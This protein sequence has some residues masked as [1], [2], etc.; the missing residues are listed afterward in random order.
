MR[1]VRIENRSRGTVLAESAMLADHFWT[2]MRGLLGRPC[3]GPGEGIVLV[4]C[5]QVHM[6]GMGY[7]IDV[8]FVALDGKVLRVVRGLRPWRMTAP[9]PGAR[10]TV[11][12]APGGMADL[13][14]GDGLAFEP[15]PDGT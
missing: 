5:N 14:E 3:P 13:A 10:Y 8:A 11:E 6:F 12:M 15:L 9:C 4:P 7:S 1:N 2:R